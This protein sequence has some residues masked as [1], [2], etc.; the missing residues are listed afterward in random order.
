MIVT[1]TT[2]ITKTLNVLKT[3][4]NEKCLLFYENNRHEGFSDMKLNNVEYFSFNTVKDI[5]AVVK[6]EQDITVVFI[7]E[8]CLFVSELTRLFTERENELGDSYKTKILSYNEFENTLVD[9]TGRNQYVLKNIELTER[10]IL[11]AN[12]LKRTDH[13]G[14]PIDYVWSQK[15]SKAKDKNGK[16]RSRLEFAET[17]MIENTFVGI[18][19][20]EKG[21]EEL[22][23]LKTLLSVKKICSYGIAVVIVDNGA[24]ERDIFDSISFITNG[25][26]V[27]V[28][29]NCLHLLDEKIESEMRT[30]SHRKDSY[31][32]S[33][34]Y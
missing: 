4:K 26:L 6:E 3:F 20:A 10:E 16:Y 2:N 32:L 34:L 24:N 21:N 9:N 11:K 23:C 29:E 5:F 1:F 25:R 8:S 12:S 31:D 13:N 33:K 15:W 30:L 28:R 18:N 19:K 14:E 27:V 22:V 17:R 7:E